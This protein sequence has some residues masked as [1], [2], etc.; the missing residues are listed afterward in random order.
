MI[1]IGKYLE[2][3]LMKE[4]PEKLTWPQEGQATANAGC[5]LSVSTTDSPPQRMSPSVPVTLPTPAEQT[6]GGHLAVAGTKAFPG[7]L[8][9]AF[10]LLVPIFPQPVPEAREVEAVHFCPPLD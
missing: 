4:E 1:T 2:G 6:R 8:K 10:F 7:D 3:R 5:G 9:L